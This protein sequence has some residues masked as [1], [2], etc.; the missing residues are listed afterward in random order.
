MNL[1]VTDHRECTEV[2]LWMAQESVKT[3]QININRQ[4]NMD[5]IVVD[6]SLDHSIRK[7]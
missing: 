7:K 5:V 1:F 3:I 2:C 4:T 6:I